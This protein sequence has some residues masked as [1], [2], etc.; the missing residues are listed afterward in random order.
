MLEISKGSSP[1]PAGISPESML[2][3]T[4]ISNRRNTDADTGG[5]GPDNLL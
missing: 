4:E 3:D 5:T 1:G 2:C